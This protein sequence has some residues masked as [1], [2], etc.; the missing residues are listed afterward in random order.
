MHHVTATACT[1][2]AAGRRG[3]GAGW[4]GPFIVALAEQC[5]AYGPD[6]WPG[7]PHGADSLQL[8]WN[9]SESSTAAPSGRWPEFCHSADALSPLLLK[10]LMTVE[11]GYSRM[12][13][14]STASHADA[15]VR[16]EC[17]VRLGHPPC[18]AAVN[19]G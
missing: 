14:S 15:D 8:N 4:R 7:R 19:T 3:A 2:N 18:G 11:G 1:A 13:A 17:G 5:C 9:R 6:G 10:N 12:T 16:A